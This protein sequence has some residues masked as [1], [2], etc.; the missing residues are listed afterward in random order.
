MAAFPNKSRCN[1]WPMPCATASKRARTGRGQGRQR[2]MAALRRPRFTPAQSLA[3]YCTAK[4]T[5][6]AARRRNRPCLDRLHV[7]SAAI[8]SRWA[9]PPSASSPRS[10]ANPIGSRWDFAGPHLLISA[11]RAAGHGLEQPGSLIDYTYRLAF[12]PNAEKRGATIE[13]FKADA[14]SGLSRRGLAN[15]RPQRRRP[16]HSPLCR[17]G[18]DVPH[19]G[20]A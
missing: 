3:K 10:T 14:A 17:A 19:P 6:S 20:G 11:R 4:M 2:Y 12:T 7:A 15:P 18:G 8:S 1:R 9:T 5:E 13:S 16:R